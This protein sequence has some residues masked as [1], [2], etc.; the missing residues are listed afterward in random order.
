MYNVDLHS[1]YP[2]FQTNF[3]I[4]S[5][6][7][8]ISPAADFGGQMQNPAIKFSM[9]MSPVIS[10]CYAHLQIIRISNDRYLSIK[11]PRNIFR[12]VQYIKTPWKNPVFQS[13]WLSHDFYPYETIKTPWCI[14]ISVL[15]KKTKPP[16]GNQSLKTRPHET[17]RSPMNRIR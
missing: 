17:P 11:I 8:K 4:I 13:S 12:Y 16:L 1:L 6:N 10:P 2:H 3:H 14:S 5:K 9:S 7:I 15:K